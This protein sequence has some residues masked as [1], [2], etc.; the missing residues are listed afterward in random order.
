MPLQTSIDQ[1]GEACS[2]RF[3]PKR[4]ISLVPSQTELLYSLGLD[5]EVVGITRFCVHPMGW[6]NVKTLIG[7]TKIFDFEVISQLNPDLIIGNKEENYLEGIA[8]L[9]KQF[10][11]WMSDIYNLQ[12]ALQM[13]TEVG[14]LVGHAGEAQALKE[15][16]SVAFQDFRKKKKRKVLY[17]IWRKPWMAAGRNTFIDDMLSRIGFENILHATRYPQLTTEELVIF[18]PEIIF[19]S[20]EPYPFKDK[21]AQELRNL[22]PQAKIILVDGEMFSWYGSRLLK[23]CDYFE[24][25]PV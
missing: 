25:L 14:K 24:N 22:M 12:D 5:Q 7:G 10:P 20:S 3:P 2:F 1:M 11:V 16:I 8:Q 15:N 19:L 6:R 21:H 13:I 18:N 4:I 17:L 9:K 23:A